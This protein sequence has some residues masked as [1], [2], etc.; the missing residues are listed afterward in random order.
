MISSIKNNAFVLLSALLLPVFIWG[1]LYHSGSSDDLASRYFG[2]GYYPASWQASIFAGDVYVSAKEQQQSQFNLLSNALR[3]NYSAA[4]KMLVQ[5][6]SEFPSAKE[7]KTIDFDVANYYFNNE[8]YRYALKWFSRISEN[9]IPKLELPLFYFNKGYTLFSA[10]RYKQAKPYLEKVKKNEEYESDAHYYLGHIAYQLDDYNTAVTEFRDISNPSQKENLTYFQA[11]MNFRLGR[12]EQAIVLA[13]KVLNEDSEEIVSEASKIIG[14][15][16][17]N[18]GEYAAAIPFL[19]AYKGKKR[20]WNDTDYYQLGFAYYQTESYE[21]A[22]TQFNKIVSVK[23]ALAQNAY[24][25]LADCYLRLNQKTAAQNAF[26]SAKEMNFDLEV[27]KDAFLNYAKLSYEIGN[28][29][30][31]PPQILV[32]F[33]EAYPKH[34]QGD[35]IRELLVNSYTKEGNYLAA[36]EILE[37]KSG[38]KNKKTLEQ[39]L[40][41]QAIVEFNN[42]KYNNSSSLF[43]RVIKINENDFVKAYAMYWLGRSEYERNQFDS[44]LEYFKAFKKHPEYRLVEA[45]NRIDYDIGYVYFKLGEYPFALKAFNQF[46]S[47]NSGF[48]S[49]YQRDTFLRM[50]DCS[51]AMKEYWSAMES[52]NKAIALNELKGAY[53]TFQKA[54]SYGFVDRNPKKI[55]TLLKLQ[56]LYPKD[57]LLDDALYEL[58]TSYSRE[59]SFDESINVYDNLLNEFDNS[60]YLAKAA[61]NK[62]LIL[63]NTE[64]YDQARKVLESVAIKYKRFTVAQQAVRTL[65]EI[66]VDQGSVVDFSQWV[67][68]QGLTTFTDIELEKTAF[69]A[70]EKRFLEGNS[71][72]AER[73][74][75]EYLENYPQGTYFLSATYYL[76]ELYF[77]RED[78]ERAQK[79]YSELTQGPVTNYSEKSLV[80]LISI[81]KSESQLNQAIP[82][83]EKLDSI[84]SFQEN[85]RFALLN[86]MQAYFLGSEYLK[87]LST[88]E[89]VLDLPDLETNLK[90][91]A[92]T[93]KAKSA[94]AIKD[95]ITAAATFIKLESAP[96]SNIVAEA[97][98]FRAFQL[99]QEQQFEQSNELIGKIAQLGS[100][101]G[102]WN[103]KALI[104]LATNYFK[105]NDSFQ[106]IFV[107]E[108]VIENFETYPE[109]VDLAKN[110]LVQ[111]KT[112]EK[113]IPNEIE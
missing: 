86:L 99:H 22:L 28:P 42:A 94:L 72:A 54:M 33:L 57:Q 74:L 5:F 21:K 47:Q 43:K 95:S 91:D 69:V 81:F 23:K 60:P 51:F 61:L 8:K 96:Q 17:F 106:A 20:K 18:Q 85:K 73:L 77:E 38:Y 40:L 32:D 12:F 13:K 62:G 88:T 31:T 90:W 83:L 49:S 100:A 29:Y 67:R 64:K 111:Y 45:S 39:V 56:S 109:E 59:G 48:D 4:E 78:F 65:R 76:A 2:L 46:D 15:S 1:Q 19:A 6:K 71:S 112:N 50:G 36:I 3:L 105:L 110:L 11:D 84:A 58:A 26:K 107:L 89:R 75:T 30:K 52:Y 35:L 10:K 63:Y 55:E 102:I 53:P 79:A 113:D 25:Y 104:L 103:V 92:L 34:E 80:R 101:S 68:S 82:Y 9:Q 24:Y 44:A 7:S 66:A 37:S 87:T 16:Y 41:F 98:Y 97:Y 70:A 108:S 14:E 93:L 27:K